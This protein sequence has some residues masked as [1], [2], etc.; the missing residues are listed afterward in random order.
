MS[1]RKAK[2]LLLGSQHGNELLGD[3]LYTYIQTY[4]A[5]LLPYITFKIGNPK[6]HARGVRFIES[7]LNRSY[8]PTAETYE[9][10]RAQELRDYIAKEKFDLILDLH[11]TVCT[12]TPCFIVPEISEEV[13]PFL[14]ASAID[15]IVLV[16]DALVHTSL[17]GV[18]PR[19]VAIEVANEDIS[20]K[21]L[22]NLCI[23]IEAYIQNK[24][25]HRLKM[26]YTVNSLLAKTEVPEE[27]I[28]SLVNFQPSPRGFIPILVGTGYNSY[29]ESTHF[30]GFKADSVEA[31]TL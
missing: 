21:L 24:A 30:L 3:E 29:K 19:A 5:H 28:S 27:E 1:I 13:R 17:V 4:F 12:Q 23:D 18:E 16:R 22:N 14:T 7:D 8:L 25:L 10:K 15:K 2:I 11:T 20:P 6:A 26:V 31:I 9:E